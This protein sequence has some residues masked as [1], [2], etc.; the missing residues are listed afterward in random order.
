MTFPVVV[1]LTVFAGIAVRQVGGVRLQIWQLMLFGAATVLLSG[2][3]APRDALRAIDTDI[4]IFLFGMFL[5][6]RA[7]VASGWLAHVAYG[8]FSRARSADSLL[9]MIV[10]GAGLL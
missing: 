5:L 1:L 7:L 8:L 10:F 6:G 9:Y 2:D 4:M 3:I